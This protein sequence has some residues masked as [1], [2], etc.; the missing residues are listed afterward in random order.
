MT[1]I[2]QHDDGTLTQHGEKPGTAGIATGKRM[3]ATP[4]LIDPT[5]ERWNWTTG[6]VEPMLD[7][8]RARLCAAVDRQRE[9]ARRPYMTQLVG[10]SF[11]Y[12]AKGREADAYR[13]L[14]DDALSVMPAPERRVRFPL[15]MAEVDATD[16]PIATVIARY[17]AG[18]DASTAAIGRIEA[19]ATRAKAAIRGATTLEAMKAAAAVKWS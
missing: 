18:Q 19:L 4:R 13:S 2:V 17:Q 7:A 5:L 10:Q 1:W 11:V 14:A 12:A 16:D 6:K 15:A 8:W 3:A 9:D